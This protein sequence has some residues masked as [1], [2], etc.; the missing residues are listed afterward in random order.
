MTI[1]PPTHLPD[2]GLQLHHVGI[3]VADEERMKA[4][5]LALGLRELKREH[6]PKY[7]VT[8]I[9][10]RPARAESGPLVQFAIPTRGTL[11]NYNGGR[12]GLHHLAFEAEDIEATQRELEARGYRFIAS[13]P[14]L[15]V[16]GLLFNFVSPNVEGLNIEI[17][18]E[19]RDWR[20]SD[21]TER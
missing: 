5:A 21:P 20:A 15:G 16:D 17:V 13:H 3:V 12:G 6:L 11:K 9:F 14:Q 2:L 10:F 7:H 19:P 1:D 8:N 18:Q 4:F